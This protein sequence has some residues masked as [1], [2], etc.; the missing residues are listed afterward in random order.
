MKFVGRKKYLQKLE[1]LGKK[2]GAKI[3]VIKG[4]RRIGKSRLAKEFG[5]QGH[6][7][8]F[9]GIPPGKNITE[10]SQKN[11]FSRKL[12]AYFN[13]PSIKSED[14]GELFTALYQLV[15]DKKPVTI[16]FDEVSWLANNDSLFLGKLKVAWDT[17]FSEH[18][19]LTLILCGSISSWIEK[20]ILSSTGFYGRIHLTMTL[21]E[22]S[23]SECNEILKARHCQVSALEKLYYFNIVGGIPWYLE[24]YTPELSIMENIKSLCFE[25]D[26]LLVHEFD[27]IFTDLFG[28]RS[29]I[30]QKIITLLVSGAKEHSAIA[31]E[32]AFSSGGVLSEYMNDLVL[33]GFISKESTWETKT[34][35]QKKFTKYR[36]KDNYM[37]FYC[38]YIEPNLNK[39][40]IGFFEKIN[41]SS[42]KNWDTIMGLQFENLILQNRHKIFN[43]LNIPKEDIAIEGPYYQTPN[44]LQRGVQVDYM[45]QTRFNTLYACEIK[46]TKEPASPDIK[47]TT[48][49]KIEYINI[50]KGFS[51]IPVLIQIHDADDLNFKHINVIDWL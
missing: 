40:N 18:H 7:Y 25:K 2:P 48:L 29:H 39:I 12:S 1:I 33:S 20:N 16:L 32:I 5:K 50:P 38:K 17:L 28:R 45:I 31:K 30:Y 26:G 37:R 27:R 35:K 21:E 11:E 43:A 13:L 15:S 34:S 24:Q 47:R 19:S 44:K 10:Q 41:L 49:K 3:A 9:S 22:L 8:E 4:R 14:W 46:F 6:F 42:L 23:L 36:L 51:I